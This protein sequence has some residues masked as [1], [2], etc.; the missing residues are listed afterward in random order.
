VFGGLSGIFL[1]DVRKSFVEHP[2]IVGFDLGRQD[3]VMLK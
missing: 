2:L 1:D 3:L